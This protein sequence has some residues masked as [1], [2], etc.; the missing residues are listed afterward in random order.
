MY[1]FLTQA[2]RS[3]SMSPAKTASY[4]LSQ[5]CPIQ[6]HDAKS[7]PS[8]QFPCPPLSLASERVSLS[9]AF[10]FYLSFPFAFSGPSAHSI[11]KPFSTIF[12]PEASH[13][14]RPFRFHPKQGTSVFD[15]H[16]LSAPRACQLK[17]WW[18]RISS[19]ILP[20]VHRVHTSAKKPKCFVFLGKVGKPDH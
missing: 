9:S 20:R 19:W 13:M 14:R 5:F 2:P 18:G 11:Q 17:C 7:P 8:A 4:S 15:Q 16:L 6:G 3:S 10:I 12:C 1:E